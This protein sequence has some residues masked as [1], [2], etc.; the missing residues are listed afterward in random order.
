MW[1]NNTV[2]A[3]IEGDQIEAVKILNIHAN[4]DPNILYKIKTGNITRGHDFALVKGQNRLYVRQY[5]FSQ[6]TVIEWNN[7]SADCEHSSSVNMFKDRLYNYLVR[8][9]YT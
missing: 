5:S 6:R 1:S 8:A 9:G 7:L 4:I 3:K 2:D